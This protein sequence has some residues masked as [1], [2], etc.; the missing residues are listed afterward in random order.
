MEVWKK[1]FLG[2]GAV[3]VLIVVVGL[4]LPREWT[5]ERSIVI[6]AKP[7][8]I[9]TYVAD[10]KKWP[11][12]SPWSAEQ[13]SS[14]TYTYEGPETGM[15]AKQSWTSKNMGSGW[16]KIVEANPMTGI[17]YDLFIDMGRF[18]SNLTGGLSYEPAENGTK[19]TWRDHGDNGYNIV[20]RYFGLMMDSHMGKELDKGLSKLKQVVEATPQ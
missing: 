12:W 16:M 8:A 9:H 6:A 4:L 2:I 11:M 15:D 20:K 18:Q 13:D 19:V 10:F 1:V 5:V 17:R 7:E 3:L 14:M